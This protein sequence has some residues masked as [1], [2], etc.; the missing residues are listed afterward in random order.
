MNKL[1]HLREPKNALKIDYMVLITLFSY[2]TSSFSSRRVVL[3]GWKVF[4]KVGRFFG[5]L[6]GFLEGFCKVKT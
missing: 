2:S 5:R 6:E 3:E 1:K 4:W